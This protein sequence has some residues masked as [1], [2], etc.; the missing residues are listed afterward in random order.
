V[1]HLFQDATI[2]DGDLFGFGGYLL[3]RHAKLAIQLSLDLRWS[4]AQTMRG[5]NW[6]GEGL[7]S[8]PPNWGVVRKELCVEAGKQAL[9][10]HLARA[11]SKCWNSSG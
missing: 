7:L 1:K 8:H 3:P 6:L 10:V 11:A 4:V 9:L 5:T 2:T